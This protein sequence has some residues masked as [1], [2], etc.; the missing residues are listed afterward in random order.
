MER[1]VRIYE[2]IYDVNK[3][4]DV[5]SWQMRQTMENHVNGCV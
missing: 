2:R 3:A 5:L 1:N 4:R